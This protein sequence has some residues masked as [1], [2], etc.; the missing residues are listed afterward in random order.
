M[1]AEMMRRMQQKD[2][3]KK[4]KKEKA[5]IVSAADSEVI[6]NCAT[7]CCADFVYSC[8]S[9]RVGTSMDPEEEERIRKRQAGHPVTV[10][11]FMEWKARFEEEMRCLRLAE[12]GPSRVDRDDR[13]SWAIF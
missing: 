13:V 1:Y 10:E 12:E 5:A 3:E 8:C 6:T 2:I 11:V 9:Q 4:K 7:L